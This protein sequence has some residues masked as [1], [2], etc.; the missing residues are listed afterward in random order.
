MTDK[1]T[2]IQTVTLH[3][4]ILTSLGELTDFRDGL[5]V[6]GV[7]DALKKHRAL[8]RP[9]FCISGKKYPTSGN[10]NCTTSLSILLSC[11]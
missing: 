10:I 3:K 5:Q 8:M 2:I 4:T 11:R 7:A 1:P 9:F 6:I